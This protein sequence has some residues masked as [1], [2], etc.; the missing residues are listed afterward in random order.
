MILWREVWRGRPWFGVPVRVVADESSL[1]AFY[2]ADGTGYGFPDGSWPWGGEHPWK[3]RGGWHGEGV[4]ILAR[5][6]DAHSLWLFWDDGPERAF[7]GWYVNLQEPFARRPNGID[8]LDHELDVCIDADGTWRWKDDE[9]L[10][11]RVAEG[12]F[13]ELEAAAIRAAGKRVV[14]R[15]PDLLPTGWE[16]WRP[17]PSWPVPVLPEGWDVV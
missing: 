15:L 13:T 14:E 7:A 6:D 2:L 8:T 3:A 11:V 16:D 17:D 5:P 4:L 1:L 12:R 10:D 9:L